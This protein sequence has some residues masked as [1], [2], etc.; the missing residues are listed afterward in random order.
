MLAFSYLKVLLIHRFISY[1]V[2]VFIE[3]ISSLTE[4]IY[5]I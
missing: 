4:I 5:K 3:L 2:V 1:H